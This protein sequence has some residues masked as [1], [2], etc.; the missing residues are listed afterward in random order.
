MNFMYRANSNCY[1]RT[2][3]LSLTSGGA[4]GSGSVP[5]GT[6]YKNAQAISGT[7]LVSRAIKM[8]TYNKQQICM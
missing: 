6:F 4:D 3:M 2:D 1:A 5:S 8:I 7:H